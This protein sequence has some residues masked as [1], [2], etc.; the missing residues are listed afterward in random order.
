MKVVQV[1]Q[2]CELELA[3]RVIDKF[4]KDKFYVMGDVALARFKH[5]L[6]NFA[7]MEIPFREV[8][9]KY[10]GEDLNGKKILMLRHGG[11]GDILFMATGASE[12]K[13]K[14]PSAIIDFAVG[15]QYQGIIE[16]NQDISHV[17]TIPVPLD[18][19]NEYHFHLIFEGI[20]EDNFKAREFNAYDLFM[21]Q[22]GFNVEQVPAEN[23]IPRIFLT[24][25]ERE[26]TKE[27][28]FSLHSKNK[29]IGIQIESSSQIRNYPQ[30]NF[31]TVGKA[32]IK[33]GYDVYYFG[34]ENQ[35]RLVQSIV[36]GLGPGSYNA[37]CPRLRDSIALASFMD[38]FIA[39]DSMF[40]HIAGAL[41]I[42]VIGIYGPFL[43]DLRMRYFKN[44]ISIDA[45][46]ACSPCFIH[47]HFQCPKGNP[48]P[49][50]S[51]ISPDLIIEVFEK[52][53][54]QKLWGGE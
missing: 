8:Y 4:K 53:V 3:G 13:R 19:W 26:I 54:E 2:E 51:L 11:G 9:N 52:L 17:L 46:T 34:G 24:S 21:M 35:D 20:I 43:G 22:M 1:G 18:A 7:I 32:L 5:L 40:I 49:C 27:K 33:K 44:A 14:Y 16:N 42:P 12:L 41:D 50:F 29:K 37:T 36:K 23:K 15:E 39:P 10:N 47:G 28:I 48:S 45:I 6:P 25:E 31:Q 30:F 38:C